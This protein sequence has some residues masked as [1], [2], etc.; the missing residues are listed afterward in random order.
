[1]ISYLVRQLACKQNREFK[2]Y[3]LASLMPSE[4]SVSS[5]VLVTWVTLIN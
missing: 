3:E 4:H 1:M 5:V 2:A